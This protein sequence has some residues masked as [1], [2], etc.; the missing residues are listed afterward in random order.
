MTSIKPIE[1]LD[2]PQSTDGENS[3]L[4]EAYMDLEPIIRDLHISNFRGR[5]TLGRWDASTAA[6]RAAPIISSEVEKSS[7]VRK[8]PCRLLLG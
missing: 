1:Y 5:T 7:D 6:P 3:R 4:S 2:R 8:A